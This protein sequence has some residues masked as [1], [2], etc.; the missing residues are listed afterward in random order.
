MRAV[1]MRSQS[2]YPNGAMMCTSGSVCVCVGIVTGVVDPVAQTSD[3]LSASVERV[4]ET[5]SDAHGR[6]EDIKERRKRMRTGIITDSEG[7]RGCHM[8]GAEEVL[9]VLNIDI[10]RVGLAIESLIIC[11]EGRATKFKEAADLTEEERAM[12]FQFVPES[13]MISLDHLASCL[14]PGED[15]RSLAA[16]L[17]FD[18]HT[19]AVAC[20]QETYSIFDPM[21]AIFLTGLSREEFENEI[22]ARFDIPKCR[23]VSNRDDSVS[24]QTDLATS[25]QADVT[26]FYVRARSQ[27]D[28]KGDPSTLC[29]ANS[30]SAPSGGSVQESSAGCQ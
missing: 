8:V 27:S 30:P 15:Q 18:S 14:L 16:T 26:V 9:G 2:S 29:D 22:F 25:L 1:R 19:I 21:P 7:S 17:T 5:A 28:G 12:P 24:K 10:E 11:E 3:E 23:G 4:M 6:I 20:C 13:C